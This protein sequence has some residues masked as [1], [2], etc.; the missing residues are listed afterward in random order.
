LLW[1]VH[2]RHVNEY[3][4]RESLSD[5]FHLSVI[6][7]I[8]NQ[9]QDQIT[10]KQHQSTYEYI[11]VQLN[12]IIYFQNKTFHRSH[13]HTHIYIYVCVCVCVCVCSKRMKCD[14]TRLFRVNEPWI[15]F[16]P[17][18]DETP[19]NHSHVPVYCKNCIYVNW[20][21]LQVI[22][23][24]WAIRW[25]RIKGLWSASKLTKSDELRF[26]AFTQTDLNEA[27]DTVQSGNL[28]YLKMLNNC[29]V[30]HRS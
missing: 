8:C 30:E 27:F 7:P 13:A 15:N 23:R 18:S 17:I 10:W 5:L 11:S 25:A 21:L 24:C 22:S 4:K 1:I 19:W 28:F 6:C 2:R 3:Y 9:H 20:H 29:L 14:T 16:V 26:W 12:P